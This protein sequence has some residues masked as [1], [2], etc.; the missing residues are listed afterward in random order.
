MQWRRSVHSD[1]IQ[2]ESNPTPRSG[3]GGIQ[4][5]QH[6]R[7][8]CL[9]HKYFYVAS[10]NADRAWNWDDFARVEIA[11]TGNQADTPIVISV[12]S[13]N[14]GRVIRVDSEEGNWIS[15]ARS[16]ESSFAPTIEGG[17]NSPSVV[18]IVGEF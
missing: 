8:F 9:S 13:W 3:C 7:A 15:V 17:G 16:G 10:A 6:P 2:Q 4:Y 5:S 11:I 18:S 1:G 12:L 14:A